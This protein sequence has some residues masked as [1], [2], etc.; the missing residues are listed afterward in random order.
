MKKMVLVGYPKNGDSLGKAVI[1]DLISLHLR[2][3]KNKT[4]RKLQDFLE[5]FIL[6]PVQY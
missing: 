5:K 1:Y 4:W 3:K 6:R 2:K